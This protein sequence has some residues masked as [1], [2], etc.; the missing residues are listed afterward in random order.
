[1]ALIQSL[2]LT[3]EGG[4]GVWLQKLTAVKRGRLVA[5]RLRTHSNKRPD[6]SNIVPACNCFVPSSQRTTSPS[7]LTV[8]LWN[9]S[10]F[11]TWLPGVEIGLW[12]RRGVGWTPSRGD[13]KGCWRKFW[14]GRRVL[15][16][17]THS[18][19]TTNLADVDGSIVQGSIVFVFVF[20]FLVV[21]QGA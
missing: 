17:R 5:K 12:E 13:K 14:G 2:R 16:A 7:I 18:V 8:K 4:H 15:R 11:L 1:M 10:K 9:R 3:G 6:Q 20:V 21:F 19:L